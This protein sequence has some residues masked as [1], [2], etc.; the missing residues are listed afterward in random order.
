MLECFFY[1]FYE[2]SLEENLSFA[3]ARLLFAGSPKDMTFSFLSSYLGWQVADRLAIP[4]S[5]IDSFLSARKKIIT[6]EQVSLSLSEEDRQDLS[7]FA[8]AL[9]D[10]DTDLVDFLFS[11]GIQK[12]EFVAASLWVEE[13]MEDELLNSRWWR[14]EA[15]GRIPGLAKNWAYGETFVLEHYGYDVT[16][17]ISERKTAGRLIFMK[18]EMRKLEEVLCRT[19]EANA[20][21]VGDDDDQRLAIVE[22]LAKEIHDG[23]VLSP[24]AHKRVFLIDGMSIIERNPDKASLEEEL[25]RIFM[26]SIETGNVILVINHFPA[27][28][29][30]ARAINADVFNSIQSYVRASTL[31]LVGLC[32]ELNFHQYIE[33]N[34]E[35]M[36]HFELIKVDTKDTSHLLE[37][38]KEEART[39]EISSGFFFT[40]QTLEAVVESAEQYFAGASPADKARD[41]LLQLPAHATTKGRRVIQQSDVF[42]LIEA[43]TGIPAG[44]I[45]E[46]EKTKLLNLEELLQQ[47]IIGQHEAISAISEAIRRSRSDLRNKNK[48]I[49]AFLFFGPTG[50]G[51]TETSKA[52]GDVFFGPMAPMVRLDMSEYTGSEAVEKLLGSFKNSKS[53]VLTNALRE[54]QYGVLLLDEFEKAGGDVLNIFL[55][56]LDEGSFSDMKGSKVSARNMIIIA[57]SNAGS[58]LIF[59]MVNKGR[60]L[61]EARPE[62]IQSII[63]Q[64]IFKPELLNRFDAA[65]IFHP[66]SKN[67]LAEV[68]ALM[69]SQFIIRLRHKGLELSVTPD[70]INYLVARGT[71]PTFGARP[72]QRVISAE[73]ESLIADEMIKGTLKKGSK[74]ELISDNLPNGHLHV[75]MKV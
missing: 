19:Q 63:S 26:Q 51:K 31:Q 27:L 35:A 5:S 65:I 32:D 28:L 50:V 6:L 2:R 8:G 75:R 34:S 57:T 62:I 58:D 46:L 59:D 42:E 49:G 45:G 16:K 25:A 20:F 44:E 72:L 68:A 52:L 53:G 14:R 10:V 74:F 1:S 4:A 55:Q 13:I 18:D 61:A 36:S 40:Y 29:L 37:M 64:G 73:I 47:R 43:K 15:I 39:I 69:L 67:E 11:L 33:S 56:I 38:L 48:P 71:D 30:S 12:E 66:L 17:E 41:L 9:Y 22:L 7:T 54:H 60:N 70:L 23:N 3:L 24:L 21:I